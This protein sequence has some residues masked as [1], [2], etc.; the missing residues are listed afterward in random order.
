MHFFDIDKREAKEIAPGVHIRTTWG[1]RMLLSVVDLSPG[2]AVPNHSHAHE[3]VGAVLTGEMTLT[4]DGETRLL[5][6]GDS[7]V[8]PGGLQH[9]ATV[10]PDGAHVIDVFSPVREEYKY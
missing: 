10:G 4:I 9:S 8:I 7:Y 3:Q 6:P 1:E 5:K 2:A